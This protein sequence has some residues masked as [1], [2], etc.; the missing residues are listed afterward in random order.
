MI[1]RQRSGSSF[2]SVIQRL[3]HF[4][5]PQTV[6]VCCARSSQ[7]C[8]S[9]A[10]FCEASIELFKSVG[11][12]R[13]KGCCARCHVAQCV[14]YS[15]GT[16]VRAT[17]GPWDATGAVGRRQACVAWTGPCLPAMV[18]SSWT[19]IR[20]ID[21][22]PYRRPSPFDCGRAT[23]GCPAGRSLED[24]ADNMPKPRDRC[25]AQTPPLSHSPP[26]LI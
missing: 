9:P 3:D 12:R 5:V 24:P 8:F 10:R 6:S 14:W 7:C 1:K 2:L 17:C 11:R 4:G 18:S 15:C 22:R 19:S 13:K 26:D 23:S 21:C 20:S 25:P 16:H